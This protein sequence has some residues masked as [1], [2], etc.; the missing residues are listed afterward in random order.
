MF[1]KAPFFLLSVGFF[2][3][4]K[5]V[6]GPQGLKEGITDLVSTQADFYTARKAKALFQ[7]SLC[8]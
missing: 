5:R 7:S 1:H 6:L 3:R 4:E 8:D 2:Q